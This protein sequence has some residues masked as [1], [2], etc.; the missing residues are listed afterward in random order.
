MQIFKAAVFSKRAK[1]RVNPNPDPRLAE[2]DS[3]LQRA[4]IV[5]WSKEGR[6]LTLEKGV[7]ALKKG[8]FA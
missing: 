1:H 7:F 8:V 4:Q 3:V 2:L 6:Q 5:A